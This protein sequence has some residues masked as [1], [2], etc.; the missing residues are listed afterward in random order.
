M[1]AMIVT[2]AAAASLFTRRLLPMMLWGSL[3]GL[4]SGVVGLYASFYIEIAS[5]PS[6]VL[7]ATLIF[8]LVFVFAPERGLLARRFA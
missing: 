6:V 2:P 5:G 1:L 3:I 7:V 4:V 8:M